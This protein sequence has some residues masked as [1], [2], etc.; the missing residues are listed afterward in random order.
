MVYL[1]PGPD[2]IRDYRTKR[3]DFT[4]YIGEVMPSRDNTGDANYLWR[5]APGTPAPLNKDLYVGGIGW[6][7]SEFRYL[8]RREMSSNY[9]I[10]LGEFHQA[11][12]DN[13]THR[14]QNPWQ[15]LY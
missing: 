14:F 7:V 3:Y 13:T 5:P 2:Y 8:N 6:G 15:V 10:K 1:F 4:G 11:C 12:E 9:Q